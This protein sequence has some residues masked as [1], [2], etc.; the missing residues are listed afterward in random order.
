[1]RQVG[2]GVGRLEGEGRIRRKMNFSYVFVFTSL[3][4]E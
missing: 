4:R 1:M 2:M 3:I